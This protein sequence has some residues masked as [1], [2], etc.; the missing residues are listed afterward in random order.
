LE[1]RRS[2]REFSAEHVT[3]EHI[4]QLLW[5]AQGITRDGKGRA[6]PSAGA[7]YPVEVYLVAG[8]VPGL[9]QGTYHYR[10]GRHDLEQRTV[11]DHRAELADA[12]LQQTWMVDAPLIIVIAAVFGRTTAEYGDRGNHYVFMEVGSVYQ[13]VHLQTAAL[14]LGTTVVGAFDDARVARVLGLPD[15]QE[16]LAMMPVGMVGR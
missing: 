8:D 14:G 9:S 15:D 11:G 16:P 3:L 13:N 6:A 1:L 10:P 7:H 4:S 5:A 12:A 2:V